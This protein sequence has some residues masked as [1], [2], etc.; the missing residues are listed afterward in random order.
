MLSCLLVCM[1]LRIVFVAVCFSDE[2][3]V[4]ITGEVVAH[5]SP[6]LTP[7]AV[8]GM[9]V[10]RIG[11]VGLSEAGVVA[12]YSIDDGVLRTFR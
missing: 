11:W 2:V 9:S 12:V 7:P 3:E 5:M 6:T 1:L 8:K 10:N 4:S